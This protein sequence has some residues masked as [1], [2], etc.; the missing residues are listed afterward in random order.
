M[1]LITLDK[2]KEVTHLTT[3]TEHKAAIIIT[4][5]PPSVPKLTRSRARKLK[6][7]ANPQHPLTSLKECER[8]E[9]ASL[10]KDELHSDEDDEEY[11]VQE[12]D[13]LVRKHL[14]CL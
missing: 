12:E 6:E 5:T 2:D 3:E 10:I 14:V 7:Q 8:N 9:V 4:D 1:A 11:V 13:L